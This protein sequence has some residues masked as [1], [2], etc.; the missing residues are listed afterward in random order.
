MSSV[1][2]RCVANRNALILFCRPG[3]RHSHD[4]VQHPATI[5]ALVAADKQ[6]GGVHRI[7]SFVD[8]VDDPDR[9][10]ERSGLAPGGSIG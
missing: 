4:W 5:E 10:T 8:L 3:E 1:W 6:T 9:S 7:S 2:E